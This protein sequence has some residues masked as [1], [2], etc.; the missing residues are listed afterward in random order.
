MNDDMA[1]AAGSLTLVQ[2]NVKVYSLRYATSS[3]KHMEKIMDD[4]DYLHVLIRLELLLV[5]RGN[6][7]LRHGDGIVNPSLISLLGESSQTT[8]VIRIYTQLVI[9]VE[10]SDDN[11]CGW[12]GHVGCVG[13]HNNAGWGDELGETRP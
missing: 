5:F 6:F 12:R 7:L 2:Y 13:L 9:G 1:A 3:S 4:D 11:D 10:D 8:L